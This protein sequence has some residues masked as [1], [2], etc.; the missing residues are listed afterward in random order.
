[1]PSILPDEAGSVMQNKPTVGSREQLFDLVLFGLVVAYSALLIAT[2]VMGIWLIDA[3]GR[4]KSTVFVSFWAAGKLVLA[5]NAAD[6]YDWTVHKAVA[7]ANDIDISGLFTFQ[8]P[9]T[10]L[11]LTPALALVPYPVAM[12]VWI[13]SSLLLYL[14]AVR[15][16]TGTWSATIAALAWPAVLW[17]AVVGQTGFLTAAL[18]GAGVAL[19]DR[20]PALSGI[21]FGLL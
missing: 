15:I 5:G 9:P 7:T 11:L 17:N 19:I 20:R 2:F 10:F 14:A 8:Y 16:V 4:P 18:L 13:A 12:L 1:D 6:A 21:L 3:D